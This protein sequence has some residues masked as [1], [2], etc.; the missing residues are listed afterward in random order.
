[1]LCIASMMPQS[2]FLHTVPRPTTVQNADTYNNSLHLKD[3]DAS[4]PHFAL[5]D[6]HLLSRFE[7]RTSENNPAGPPLIHSSGEGNFV[8]G[9]VGEAGFPMFFIIIGWPDIERTLS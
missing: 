3:T 1:M 9:I 4:Y 6:R 8:C 5:V 7:E 2:N